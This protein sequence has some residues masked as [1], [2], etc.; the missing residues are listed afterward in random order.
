MNECFTRYPFCGSLAFMENEKEQHE[1]Y[2]MI[3][4][5]RFTVG[6]KGINLFG[7]SLRHSSGITMRVKTASKRRDLHR[8]WIHG[9][10]LILELTLSPTQF[11]DLITSMNIGDGVPCTL[12]YVDGKG[13]PDCPE[14]QLRQRFDAEVKE[15]FRK[16]MEDAQA[17]V[18]EV[19]NIF[20]E[21]DRLAKQDRIHIKNRLHALI[22]HIKQ[23]IPF[24]Y[25]QFNEAM[26]RTVTEAKGEVE[27]FVSNK[28]TSLGIDALEA[29][30]KAAL[31]AP[32]E[33]VPL[34]LRGTQE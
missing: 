22:Q 28:I 5:S 23:N 7:S 20:F 1:S 12:G 32:L 27:A 16:A 30:V 19:S 18:D 33:S 25:S 31:Q 13:V 24:L 11:A 14:V 3:G 26:D 34:Q 29:E 21:K 10:D 15:D 2:G 9:E 8:D 17:I 4:F 6:G